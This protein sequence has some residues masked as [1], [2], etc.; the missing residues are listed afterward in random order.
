MYLLE[1]QPIRV[2]VCV[3]V[4]VFSSSVVSDSLRPFGLQP[5]RL[6]CSWD[7]SGK[8]YWSGLLFPTPR[9]LLDPG[10]K[11]ASLPSPALAGGFLTPSVS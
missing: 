9:Y 5:S 10:I 8:K 2:C 6:L 7:F 3:C 1:S 11:P 4:C